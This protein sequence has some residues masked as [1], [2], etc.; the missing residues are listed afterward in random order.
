MVG[1]PF[2]LQRT[3]MVQWWLE[4]LE[5]YASLTDVVETKLDEADRIALKKPSVRTIFAR[6]SVWRYQKKLL[7]EMKTYKFWIHL[8]SLSKRRQPYVPCISSHHIRP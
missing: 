2:T 6:T 8:Y 7:M 3:A 5:R 4:S 1:E